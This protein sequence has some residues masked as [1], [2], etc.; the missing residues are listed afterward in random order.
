VLWK[1]KVQRHE[2]WIDDKEVGKVFLYRTD[3]LVVIRFCESL[4]RRFFDDVAKV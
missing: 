3:N 4:E 2:V 1:A